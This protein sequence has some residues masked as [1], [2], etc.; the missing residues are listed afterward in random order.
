MVIKISS[1]WP[2]YF[3]LCLPRTAAF[4]SCI[5]EGML[6][7]PWKGPKP[8]QIKE[9]QRLFTYLASAGRG[10]GQGWQNVGTPLTTSP[11]KPSRHCSQCCPV[12]FLWQSCSGKRQNGESESAAW[13]RKRSLSWRSG[14]AEEWLM[15]DLD[16]GRY[17]QIQK[18]KLTQLQIKIINYY[19]DQ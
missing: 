11:M 12:V 9:N 17:W 10:Q 5:Q 4:V 14:Q 15:P 16:L 6:T 2:S 7:P 3:P 18:N 19:N 13:F 8:T 1:W